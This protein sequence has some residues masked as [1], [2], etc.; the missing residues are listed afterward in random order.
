MLKMESI[1][2]LFEDVSCVVHVAGLAH[3]FDRPSAASAP[4]RAVSDERTERVARL[5]STGGGTPFSLT[6][7]ASV[8]GSGKE[9]VT[10]EDSAC[11]PI[12]SVRLE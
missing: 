9:A 3:E 10:T 12:E 5:G 8:R 4:L 11:L 7:S 2:G 6:S 1:A